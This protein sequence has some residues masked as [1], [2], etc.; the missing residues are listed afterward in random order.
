MTFTPLNTKKEMWKHNLE[1]MA[2]GAVGTILC[3]TFGYYLL[4]MFKERGLSRGILVRRRKYKQFELLTIVPYHRTRIHASTAAS[5]ATD[6]CFTRALD[7]VDICNVFDIVVSRDGA[8]RSKERAST[9]AKGH[10]SD[11]L[12]NFHNHVRIGDLLQFRNLC[13]EKL[14]KKESIP[15]S[16]SEVKVPPNT[17]GSLREG[18]SNYSA[19]VAR[20]EDVVLEKPR[21][22]SQKQVCVAQS[23]ET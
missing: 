19:Y 4:R 20:F 13:P 3:G 15:E 12:S 17:S 21:L 9:C 11:Q 8:A 5:S 7:N 16:D 18:S 1:M 2:V 14:Q 10:I 22:W 23:H 6:T